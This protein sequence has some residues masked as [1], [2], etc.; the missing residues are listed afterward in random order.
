VSNDLPFSYRVANVVVSFDLHRRVD[1]IRLYEKWRDGR[2]FKE[3]NIV[4][5]DDDD[6]TGWLDISPK[7]STSRLKM[8]IYPSGKG[9]VL[10]AKSVD[11]ATAFIASVQKELQNV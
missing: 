2:A 3:Y 9:F 5:Y 4:I 6:I 11:E 7:D 10:G 1:T 8:R